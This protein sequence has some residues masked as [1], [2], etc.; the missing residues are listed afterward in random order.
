[1]F[2][3]LYWVSRSVKY[4]FREFLFKCSPGWWADSRQLW[5]R[6]ELE[7]TNNKNWNNCLWYRLF[8]LE[9]MRDV[10]EDGPA[11]DVVAKVLDLVVVDAVEEER[12]RLDVDQRGH[13]PVDAIDLLRR[14]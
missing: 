1:M 11:L 8:Y 14:C 3:V 12:E 6:K 2:R 13:D 10:V 9:E 5:S 4:Q 7:K